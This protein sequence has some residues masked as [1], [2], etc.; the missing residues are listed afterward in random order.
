MQFRGINGYYELELE[1]QGECRFR[2][3]VAKTGST[4]HT[5]TPAQI[6]SDDAT[7]D[8]EVV[9][10]R[11][12]LLSK[13]RLESEAYEPRQYRLAFELDGSDSMVGSYWHRASGT[14]GHNIAG[15]LRGGR[16]TLLEDISA[17]AVEVPCAFECIPGCA[18]ETSTQACVERCEVGKPAMPCGAPAALSSVPQ[19]ARSVMDRVGR[20]NKGGLTARQRRR[21]RKVAGWLEGDWTLYV[22][23]NEPA[24]F[25]ISAEDD[26]ELTFAGAIQ[27]SGDV[28][29]HGTWTLLVIEKGLF[30]YHEVPLF[31]LT[32]WGPA[33]GLTRDLKPAAAYRWKQ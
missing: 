23:G 22:A 29:S 11:V 3:R 28:D 8:A 21:C 1:H 5:N 17:S 33:F 24:D 19:R 13:F 31:A 15:L 9:D 18:D 16:S 27:G 4:R 32:G 14:A 20:A 26:C 12:Q 30:G 6:S 2:A 25:Q 10:G 7:I